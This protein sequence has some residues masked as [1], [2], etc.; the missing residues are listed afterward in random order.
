LNRKVTIDSSLRSLLLRPPTTR[1]GPG[2][3]RQSKRDTKPK[4]VPTA[5]RPNPL[6]LLGN[7]GPLRLGR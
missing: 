2:A 6:W 4:S 5:G 7:P 1:Y 3:V